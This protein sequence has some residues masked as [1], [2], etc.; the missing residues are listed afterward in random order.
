[1]ECFYLKKVTWCIYTQILTDS[2]ITLYKK[3]T[4]LM[5]CGSVIFIYLHYKSE[6]WGIFTSPFVSTESTNHK[7]IRFQITSGPRNLICPRTRNASFKSLCLCR[8]YKLSKWLQ[9]LTMLA[10]VHFP[11]I[12]LPV[13]YLYRIKHKWMLQSC[14]RNIELLEFN[15]LQL[16][17]VWLISWCQLHYLKWI[18]ET[19]QKLLWL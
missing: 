9:F 16:G 15:G 7:S 10:E 3:H 12:F 2:W 13:K 14:E 11:L 19:T 18:L 1:M 4:F 17:I 6:W 5:Y 8:D